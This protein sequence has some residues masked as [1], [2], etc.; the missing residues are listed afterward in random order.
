[1]KSNK[2]KFTIPNRHEGF[3]EEFL[4]SLMRKLFIG[5]IIIVLAPNM[6]KQVERSHLWHHPSLLMKP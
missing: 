5:N 1:M 6:P 3:N 2:V 4:K